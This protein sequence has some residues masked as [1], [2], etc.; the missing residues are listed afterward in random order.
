LRSRLPTL[1]LF[2]LT[3]SIFIRDSVASAFR[4]KHHYFLAVFFATVT[5]DAFSTC[6]AGSFLAATALRTMM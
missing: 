3:T 6:G 1:S 2:E 5:F 4:R